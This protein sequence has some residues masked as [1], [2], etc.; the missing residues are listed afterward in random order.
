MKKKI[1]FISTAVSILLY[2]NSCKSGNSPDTSSIATDSVTIATGETSFIQKC[3]GC[4]N[5]RQDGIGPQ[6]GGIT[7]EASVDWIQ[8]FIM[9][10]KKIIESGDGRAQTLYKKFHLIMP[11]FGSNSNDQIDAFIAFLNTHKQHERLLTSADSNAL[12]NP[13]PKPIELSKLVVGLE[14]VTQIPPSSDSGKLPLTR[15][16]EFECGPNNAGPFI[17]DLRGKLYKLNNNRA[18]VYMD[19]AKLEPKF[20][21]EPGLATGFGSFSFHPDFLR[22]GLL[23]TTHSESRGSAKADFNFP[24]SIKPAMQWVITEWK[25]DKPGAAVFSGTGRELFRIDMVSGI[26]GVQEIT[27]NPLAKKGDEDYGL[28]YIGIGDGGAVE[29]GY[30]WLAHSQEKIWG[31]V[32]RIDPAGRNSANGHYGIPSNNPFAKSHADK[33]A[34]EIYAFGFRNPHRITWS[35]S[36]AM[37][38]CN[39]GHHNIESVN[40]VMPGHDYGWPIRE[41]TFLL[42]PYG[43]LNKVYPLSPDDSIYHVTYPIAQYD[44]DEGKAIS[45]GYEYWGDALPALKGKYFFG[46]IP[47][48]RLFY[49]DMADIKQGS[50]ATI[51]EWKISINGISKTLVEL[52]GTDRVALHFGRDDKGEL[53]ILTKPDGKVYKLVSA[54]VK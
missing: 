40:L 8:H 41:G 27:F 37:L 6:L 47:K 14:L 15:I 2:F 4:H 52:C 42:N 48:A 5:F 54:I 13:I 33:I 25:T 29:N 50:Q 1:L 30:A 12:K 53:Y 21:H 49:V 23:Y 35:K 43:D 31:S 44:H 10:P 20:I 45:G 16:T 17:L 22:N 9:D 18:T 32:L 7:T 19:M 28:L 34:K 26:H 51:K 36:G 38:V 24:D 11:S 3:S 39:I 46:D